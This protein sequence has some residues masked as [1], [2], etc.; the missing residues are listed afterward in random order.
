MT[1]TPRRPSAPGRTARIA[2][3][4]AVCLALAC[5]AQPAFAAG[6][7]GTDAS[8]GMSMPEHD[9]AG[10]D[11]DR[12]ADTDGMDHGAATT[13]TDRGAHD[14]SDGDAPDDAP[15]ALS[16][17]S[18]GGL[19]RVELRGLPEPVPLNLMHGWTVHVETVDGA[20]VTGASIAMD[21]G[22][23]IHDH[24]LPTA[25]RVTAELGDGDYRLEGVRFQMPGHW[26]VELAID[27]APGTD[28]VTFD[29][30]L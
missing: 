17:T 16:G 9:G 7:A 27:A 10:H 2:A 21:G 4:P 26:V 23:P 1:V 20:P 5:L 8:D 13:G 22:M 29:L 3:S 12:D 19:Y 24:G 15:V 11:A 30:N 25:P 6:A 18:A 28:S 14:G